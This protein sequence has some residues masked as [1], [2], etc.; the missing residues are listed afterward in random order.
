MG[1][2]GAPVALEDLAHPLPIPVGQG[3]VEVA[4]D[5][6]D[7]VVLLGHLEGHSPDAEAQ[8]LRHG[9]HGVQ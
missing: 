5:L 4:Q 1:L 8:P 2:Q 3:A 9:V 6:V 7:V